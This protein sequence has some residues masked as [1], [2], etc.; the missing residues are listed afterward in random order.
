MTT[1]LSSKKRPV[2]FLVL[3]FMYYAGLI[4]FMVGLLPMEDIA[5][6]DAG[7]FLY[8]SILYNPGVSRR[9]DSGPVTRFV[10]MIVDGLRSDLILSPQYARFWKNLAKHLNQSASVRARSFIQPP[11][12]TMPRIKVRP[13]CYDFGPIFFRLLRPVECQ[14]LS[15]CCE[16]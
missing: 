12:V 2:Q 4:V 16:T 15:T 8:D 9:T 1:F 3:T 6:K 10:L 13:F 14:N 5:Y 11:T 7:K